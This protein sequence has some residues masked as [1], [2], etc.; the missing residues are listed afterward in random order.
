MVTIIEPPLL[1][2][3]KNFTWYA[4]GAVMITGNRRTFSKKSKKN[5]ECVPFLVPLLLYLEY[6]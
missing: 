3:I 4:D 2:K 1:R 6:M 5:I